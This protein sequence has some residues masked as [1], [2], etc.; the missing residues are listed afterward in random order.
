MLSERA[1]AALGHII[2]NIERARQGLEGRSPE[3]LV[4]D[5]VSFYAVVR[6]LEIISEA[7]RRLG[8]ELH[9]RHP[10]VSWRDVADAGNVYRHGYDVVDPYLVHRTVTEHLGPL[11]AAVR[12]ELGRLVT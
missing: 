7:S 1:Q 6:C 10:E 2:E 9:D 5:W 4:A 12:E 8:P 11:E 3:A